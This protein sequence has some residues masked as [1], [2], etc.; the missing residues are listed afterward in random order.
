MFARDRGDPTRPT[1]ANWPTSTRTL[2]RGWNTRL[3]GTDVY[4]VGL[5]SPSSYASRS[6]TLGHTIFRNAMT[7]ASTSTFL[8]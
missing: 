7:S 2:C 1:S 5:V 8:S 3:S 4:T 6:T